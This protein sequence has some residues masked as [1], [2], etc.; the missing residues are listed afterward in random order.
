LRWEDGV[1][2]DMRI[3]EVKNWKMVAFDTDEWAKI[4]KKARGCRPNDDDDDDETGSN[5]PKHSKPC[6]LK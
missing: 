4:L 5:Q 1:D 3:S 6:N 2:Q